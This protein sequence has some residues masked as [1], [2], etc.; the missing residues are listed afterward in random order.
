[1]EL[2]TNKAEHQQDNNQCHVCMCACVC[3][4]IHGRTSIIIVLIIRIT[5]VRV[6]GHWHE[7]QQGLHTRTLV[8]DNNGNKNNNS[9][10]NDMKRD[11]T[12]GQEVRLTTTILHSYRREIEATIHLEKCILL[13]SQ[14]W[15]RL[16]LSLHVL[17]KIPSGYL[18]SSFYLAIYLSCLSVSQSVHVLIF[19]KQ[20][21]YLSVSLSDWVRISVLARVCRDKR[22]RNM[23]VLLDAHTHSRLWRLGGDD[24]LGC[25]GQRLCGSG[26]LAPERC[27]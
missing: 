4:K 13:T 25:R 17:L 11:N 6:G 24:S 21:A 27:Y 14:E 26:L 15:D 19:C 23:I 18:T 22:M 5:T 12:Q 7:H 10:N 16:S 2:N 1:M 3:L 8:N 9:N 20:Y